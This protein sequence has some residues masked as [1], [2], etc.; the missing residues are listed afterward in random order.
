MNERSK[1]EVCL[2]V[3]QSNKEAW[4]ILFVGLLVSDRTKVE[5]TLFVCQSDKQTWR[6]FVCL[7]VKKGQ[8]EVSLFVH[9]LKQTHQQLMR[10]GREPVMFASHSPGKTTEGQTVDDVSIVTLSVRH[11]RLCKS[12]QESP[13]DVTLSLLWPP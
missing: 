12:S 2:F 1:F 9:G 11:L 5:V 13:I 10:E 6:N 7:S 4:L 3:C 8:A